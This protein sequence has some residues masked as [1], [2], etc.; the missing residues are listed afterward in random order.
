MPLSLARLVPVGPAHP[1]VRRY[2]RARRNLLPRDERVVAVAGTW[3]MER[4]LRSGAAVETALWCVADAPPS[5]PLGGM[6]AE[7]AARARRAFRISERTLARIHPGIVAPTMVAVARLP[8][9]RPADVLTRGPGLVLVADGIEY[10][11]NL[12]TLVRTA[13][14]S[15]ADAVVLTGCVARVTHP[16]TFV[17]S[18][19]TV[20]TLPVLEY[21][22]VG[23][24]RA[25]LVAAGFTACV[26]DPAAATPYRLAGLGD[27]PTAVVVGSEGEGVSAQW[28]EGLPHVSIPMLGTADSL[29][30]AASA[31][32]LMFEA[33]A[34]LGERRSTCPRHPVSTVTP[35]AVR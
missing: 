25:D 23:L 21:A 34:A 33:R 10:A 18:R 19:G 29:N 12:G 1:D 20:L 9:W 5:Q 17:A 32:V 24:A 8:E 35:S 30:V 4:L 16:K 11:G 2:S 6:P 3:A 28:R 7:V 13:D 26:A 31:A 27:G 22:S 15:G 14:A